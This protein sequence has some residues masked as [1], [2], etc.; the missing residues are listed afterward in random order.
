L[1][2]GVELAEGRRRDRR[3][4]F[5]EAILAAVTVEGYN[6]D[7]ARVHGLL[8]VE[9]RKSGRSRGAHDLIIA[10]TARARGREVISADLDGFDGL[11]GVTLRR[12]R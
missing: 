4:A 7:V 11:S 8:L 10:A 2:V 3:A 6:L 9:T 12:H 1:T 5:V